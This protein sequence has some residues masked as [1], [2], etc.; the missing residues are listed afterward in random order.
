MNK[1]DIHFKNLIT[2]L[3]VLSPDA[4][5]DNI[6][7]KYLQIDDY[8]KNAIEKFLAQF[9]YWGKLNYAE[10]EFEE[11][12]L[13]AEVLK[14]H[15]D[16]F[17]NLF[18]KLGDYRSK[19]VLYGIL[20]YWYNS[21]FNALGSAREENYSQYFDLDLIKPDAEEVYVDV[22]AYTGDTILNYINTY[23]I[24]KKI[25]AYEITES[26]IKIMQN[27]LKDFANIDIRK[28]A[29]KDIN[30]DMHV[31]TNSISTSAN[32]VTDEGEEKVKCV[33]LDDDLKE[34]ITLIKMDIE[35]SE[36]KALIGATNHIKNDTPKLLISV[37]HNHDD[38]WKLPKLINT[39]NDNYTFYLRYFG[40]RYY[41][42][43]VVLIALPK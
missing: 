13:R 34:K 7:T 23:G 27:T 39:I 25:Y 10:G 4:I 17:D 9:N 21:D 41:P 14:N 8:N 6:K 22:G 26:S 18:D 1:L 40:N 35:G 31:T 28:L 36:E 19:K 33:T 29:L 32:T 11:L 15:V 3:K 43:E 30:G 2:S 5:F 42:T 24:Y 16:D 38:L 37:Y 12:K 20:N